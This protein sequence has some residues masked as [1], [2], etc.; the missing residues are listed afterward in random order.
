MLCITNWHLP[1]TSTRIKSWTVGAADLQ[2][3]LQRVQGG[4][5]KWRRHSVLWEKWQNRSASIVRYFQEK[6][7]RAQFL[8]LLI[9][10]KSTKIINSDICSLQWAVSLCQ[11][12]FS[13]ACT[14][15][16]RNI[17]DTDLLPISLE[18]FLRATWVAR[19]QA[20][21]LI[22]PQMKLDPQLSHCAS[23]FAANTPHHQFSP[24]LKSLPLNFQGTCLFSEI[25]GVSF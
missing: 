6:I 17:Y 4:D 14:P 15:L 24:F 20:I 11:N 3:P 1:S 23:V 16:T 22:L 19:S 8:H 10:R 2:H 13:A 9:S 21:V 18:L 25:P 5:Q 7:L 12:V